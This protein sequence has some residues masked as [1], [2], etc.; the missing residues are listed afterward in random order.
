MSVILESSLSKDSLDSLI[1][2]M[3]LDQKIGQM[4][5]AN[6]CGGD[7]VET[8][9]KLFDKYHFGGLQFSGVFQ[10]FV[11]GGNY[12]PCG[13]SAN[14]PLE[15][16]AEFLHDIKAAGKEITGIPVILGGDQEGCISSSIFRR[17]NFTVAP[18]QM[19]F[20]ASGNLEDV[21]QAACITAKE[22]KCMGL[23]MLYGPSLDINTNP[24]NPEIGARSFGEDAEFVAACGLQVIKAY[25]EYKIISTAKHFPGRGH[26]ISNAHHELESIDL[27]IERLKA[28]ELLPFVRAIN[29]GVAAVMVS[30]TLFPAFGGKQLPASLS[31]EIIGYLRNELN[32]QGLVIP[33]T[34]TMFA[35]SKNYSVPVACAMCL[36]AGADMVFM[37]VPS[38]FEPCIE[39]IKKTVEAGRLSEERINE[40][41]KRILAIKQDNELFD[42]KP[43]SALEINQTVG[44]KAHVNKMHEI[45]Q[46]TTLVLQN[47]NGLLPLEQSDGLKML[48]ITPRDANVVLA[49]DKNISHDLL[50]NKVRGYSSD[51]QSVLVDES[52][53]EIQS[54]EALA[55]SKNVDIILFGIY[56][57][58][59]SEKQFELLESL[60]RTGKPIV[61]IVTG[62]PYIA[63]QISDKVSAIICSFAITP[64]AFECVADALFGQLN[65]T[66]TSPVT[67][68]EK[69]PKGFSVKI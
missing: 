49:N 66:A 12:L 44:A 38:L 50:I 18:H 30:H 7:T 28:V 14:L 42:A 34:L 1:D 9:K 25:N 10:R 59:L 53:T 8:A 51:A 57:A 29:A 11:R 58:G 35:I 26:G 48:V 37:K 64:G 3:S 21:Y 2:R 5:M 65:P 4:F 67:I 13:V 36:E 41:V 52:P 16:V 62:S 27:S 45:N 6:I 24:F 46:R 56:S 47:K 55:R 23:D 54:Y 60:S 61:A 20:G 39:E 31:P 17:R 63:S 33:D 69:M 15:E 19:G 40:S 32:F 43:F 22:V 68:S